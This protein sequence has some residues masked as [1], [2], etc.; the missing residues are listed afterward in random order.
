MCIRDSSYDTAIPLVEFDRK[1]PYDDVVEGLPASVEALGA[2]YQRQ[3]R[4][5][6]NGQAIDVYKTPG[7]RTG[8]YSAPVSGCQPYMLLNYNDTLDAAFTLAHEMGHSM[9]T[10]SL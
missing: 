5:V 10:L 8:A 7:K 1:Y 6:L 3:M 9:H 2:D 4:E